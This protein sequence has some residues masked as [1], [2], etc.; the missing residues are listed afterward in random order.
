M[1]AAVWRPTEREAYPVLGVESYSNRCAD[2]VVELP[3]GA[4]SRLPIPLCDIE[5]RPA[6]DR[7]VVRALTADFVDHSDARSCGCGARDQGVPRPVEVAQAGAGE[8]AP[9]TK[10]QE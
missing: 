9:A 4:K 2:A 10:P 6:P 3:D 5:V 7:S 8:A 1:T